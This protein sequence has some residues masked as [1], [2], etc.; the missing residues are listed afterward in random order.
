MPAKTVTVQVKPDPMP[1]AGQR[2]GFRPRSKRVP[3]VLR[4]P[5]RGRLVVIGLRSTANIIGPLSLSSPW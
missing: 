4:N 5:D 3:A 2:P 1:V